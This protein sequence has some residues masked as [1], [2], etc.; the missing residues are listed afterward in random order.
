MQSRPPLAMKNRCA[1]QGKNNRKRIHRGECDTYK[2]E[3]VSTEVEMFREEIK[4]VFC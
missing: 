1:L 3:I 4:T 2:M